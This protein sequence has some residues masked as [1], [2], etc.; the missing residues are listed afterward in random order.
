M[1]TDIKI[2]TV[3][4]YDILIKDVG[5]SSNFDGHILQTKGIQSKKINIFKNF[6][7]PGPGTV[8]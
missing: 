4:Y 2:A 6:I 7:K 5:N 1:T 3:L 8:C